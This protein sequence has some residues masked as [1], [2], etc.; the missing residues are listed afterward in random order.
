[1]LAVA[2]ALGLFSPK[3]WGRLFSTRPFS[4][5]CH[6]G[7]GTTVNRGLRIQRRNCYLT[8]ECRLL[9]QTVNTG[10]KV[11]PGTIYAPIS[12]TATSDTW[13][14]GL[15]VSLEH[16]SYNPILFFPFPKVNLDYLE[17]GHEDLRAREI[18]LPIPDIKD[19]YS[20]TFCHF[21]S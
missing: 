17:W 14:Q 13:T 16:N 3:G 4:S 1:M 12:S 6:I 21:P 20:M 2:E 8:N 7:L 19:H 18:S 9:N 11:L 10:R 5:I 15:G